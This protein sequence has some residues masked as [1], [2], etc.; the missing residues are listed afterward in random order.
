MD[1]IC[2]DNSAL[3]IFLPPTPHVE[4]YD[5]GDMLIWDEKGWS[6]WHEPGDFV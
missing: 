5:V 2:A 3:K 4:F 1:S 6:L